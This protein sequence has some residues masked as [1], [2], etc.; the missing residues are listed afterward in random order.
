[1]A[2]HAAEG[3]RFVDLLSFDRA[4]LWRD[5]LFGLLLILPSMVF[6]LGGNVGASL[7]VYGV[8]QP[9]MFFTPLPLPAA[10]YAVLVFPLLWGITEQMTYNGYAAPRLQVLS[11]STMAAVAL[12]ALPWAFQHAVM[13]VTL[14]AQYV[15]YRMIS[16][17]PFSIF[18][19][20]LYLRVR[21][22]LPFVVAHWLMD[23]AASAIGSLLPLLR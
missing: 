20:L 10:L 6:I 19:V 11:R 18:S 13:P 12:V 2:F 4:R 9:A 17:I 23:G 8:A 16:P 5:V 21:R 7:L 22:L 15:V 1:V 14:D 3:I